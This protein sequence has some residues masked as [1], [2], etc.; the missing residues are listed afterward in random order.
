[1]S[2]N[3]LAIT[4]GISPRIALLDRAAF[5]LLWQGGLRLAEVEELRLEDLNLG[6][7]QL[8]VRNGKGRKDRTVY[9]TEA[10]ILAL[11]D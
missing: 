2:L 8:T 6:Q 7:K 10:V 9:L 4:C 11:N 5:Y 1:M 3:P